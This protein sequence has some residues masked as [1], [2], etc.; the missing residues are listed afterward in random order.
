MKTGRITPPAE[1]NMQNVPL[2]T[3]EAARVRE[4]LAADL[5]SAGDYAG[6]EARI[7]AH[8]KGEAPK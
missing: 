8:L 5:A 3:E 7:L 2:R 4:A 6:I 1:P